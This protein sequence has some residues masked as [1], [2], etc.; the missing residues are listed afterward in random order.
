MQ[1]REAKGVHLEYHP[2]H[3]ICIC[4]FTVIVRI[5][6]MFILA[7]I[8]TST[9]LYCNVNMY[10]HVYPDHMARDGTSYPC[11]VVCVCVYIYIYIASQT[12]GIYI[13]I[14]DENVCLSLSLY[15]YIYIYICVLSAHV[16][17]VSRC[18]LYVC[19]YVSIDLSFSLSLSLYI[20][21]RCLMGGSR[22]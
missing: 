18:T 20:Y 7:S 22:L 8:L 12:P 6:C 4:M 2:M 19:M 1:G 10:E 16:T 3:L 21:I 17:Y 11:S 9:A 5:I 14:I 15:I 13:Y